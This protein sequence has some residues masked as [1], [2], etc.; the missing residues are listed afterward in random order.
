L[1]EFEHA[2]DLLSQDSCKVLLI[3]QAPK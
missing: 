2:I 3:P 1:D